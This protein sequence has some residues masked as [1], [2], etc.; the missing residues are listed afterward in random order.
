MA[1]ICLCINT[2]RGVDFSVFFHT[3][4]KGDAKDAFLVQDVIQEIHALGIAAAIWAVPLALT[5]RRGVCL[6]EWSLKEIVPFRKNIRDDRGICAVVQEHYQ[7]LV[8]V[9]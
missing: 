2:L 7:A 6:R 5:E 3:V 4:G 8:E 1:D 9:D